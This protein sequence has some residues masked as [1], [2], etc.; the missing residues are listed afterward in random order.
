[1]R[2]IHLALFIMLGGMSSSF[3]QE[4]RNLSIL[5]GSPPEP[6]TASARTLRRSSGKNAMRSSRLRSRK[7]RSRIFSASDGRTPRNSRLSSRTRSNISRKPRSRTRSCRISSPRSATSFRSMPRKSTSSRP[8]HPGSPNF[9]RLRASALR[10]EIWR[11]GPISPRPSFCCS[12]TLQSSPSRSTR[13]RRC[14]GSFC[15]T[16]R[17][18]RSTRC[19]MW[20]A[21]RSAC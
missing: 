14:R 3:A 21:S 12:R 20:P 19:S 7:A 1:M 2:F 18:T 4:M 9:R 11:A 16:A 8:G 13:S 15:R 17:R 10:S 5:T 6:I